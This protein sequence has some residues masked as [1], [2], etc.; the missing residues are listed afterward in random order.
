MELHVAQ[1]MYEAVD[2]SLQGTL[3][4]GTANVMLGIG[5]L[6]GTF[7]LLNFTLKSIFWLYQGMTVAFRDAVIEIA[8]VAAIAG[9][10]WN[11]GWYAS[12]IVPFV[13]GLPTWMGGILSGQAGSQVNQI[14][15]LVVSYCENLQHI[16]M[17]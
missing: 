8:K 4:S 5:A 16:Y 3:A 12:T 7:W 17:R 1:N 6:F 10:A 9:L 2:A 14:D 13:T 11:V 15:A